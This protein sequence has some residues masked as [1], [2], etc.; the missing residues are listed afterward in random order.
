MR[1]KK[2]FIPRK[3]RE[4]LA[5]LKNLV[6]Y[7]QGK[8]PDW[9]LPDEAF[10]AL[11][12]MTSDFE[13]KF[14]TAD[15]PQTRTPAA[16]TAKTEAQKE[17]EKYT[18]VFLKGYITY[19]P[20]VTD[21]DRRNMALPIHDTKPTPIPPSDSHPEC[22]TDT[23]V[24]Q[25][26]KVHAIDSM[27]G[28]KSKSYGTHGIEIIYVVQDS[29]I[30][31]PNTP[32]ETFTHSAFFTRTPAILDFHAEERGKFFCFRARWESNRGG[33]GP[34]CEILCVRIP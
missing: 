29:V 16:I 3:E 24:I 7:I 20:I 5:W 1:E 14:N 21:E 28:K 12:N 25:R 32:E 31:D 13:T 9:R 26:V 8:M 27:T 6:S 10:D 30:E 15:D 11:Q 2:D 33:K 4:F 22:S 17:V 18:R 34:F 19:N 23:S